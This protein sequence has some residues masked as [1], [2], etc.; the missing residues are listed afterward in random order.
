[1][2]D[3]YGN[4]EPD[5]PNLPPPPSDGSGSV[6]TGVYGPDCG[7]GCEQCNE[8]CNGNYTYCWD[9][10]ATDDPAARTQCHAECGQ[11]LNDCRAPCPN[12]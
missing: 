10:C 11:E 3:A 12:M 8:R 6:D 5:N 4:C 7:I 9:A 1:M 2:C